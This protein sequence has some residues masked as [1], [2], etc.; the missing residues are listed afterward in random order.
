MVSER[1][2]SVVVPCWNEASNIEFMVA[3]FRQVSLEQK[4]SIR[5][6]FVDDGSDDSTWRVIEAACQQYRQG[7]ESSFIVEGIRLERHSGKNVAQAIGLRHCMGSRLVVF[8]DGDR[9]HPISSIP[10]LINKADE[11]GQPVIAAR[12]GYSRQFTT[13]AGVA[14][15]RLVMKIL[16]VPFFPN[17]SEYLVLPRASADFLASSRRLGVTPLLELVQT[18]LGPFSAVSVKVEPRASGSGGSRWTL[19][20]LWRKALLQLFADPWRLLP[21]MTFMAVMAFILLLAMVSISA[22]HATLQG[23]SPGTVAI[24]L[25]IV[26]LA[27]IS[28]GMWVVSI[29]VSVVTLRVLESQSESVSYTLYTA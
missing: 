2:V 5:V 10:V 19:T 12:S 28:V 14:V 7:A 22:V 23:T 17:L 3:G 27:A 16:G 4:I 15:L 24:L 25:S 29:V 21:R 6:V 20:E 9:Q 8:M 1:T 11:S 18:A 13:S 26:V